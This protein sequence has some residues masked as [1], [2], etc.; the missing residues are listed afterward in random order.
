MLDKKITKI[1]YGAALAALMFTIGGCA[2]VTTNSVSG[3]VQE[4]K[5]DADT[6][7]PNIYDSEDAAVVVKKDTE[8]G[9][10]QLQNIATSRRYTL[11]Y[12]G[13]TRIFDKN[14]V[15]LSMQQLK[16][17]SVVTV[18]FYKP[19]KSLSY[20]KENAEA[21]SLPSL[22]NYELDLKNGGITVGKERY[23]LSGSVVVVSDGRETEPWEL[24]AMD[25]ISV[26]GY[27]DRIYGI[28][29]EKGHGYLR[30]QNED[31][32]VNGWV[33]VGD[34]V[35][36]K[37]EEDMLLVVPEGTYNAMVSH[38]GSSAMQ[39]ITFA[40]NE[41]MVW[42]LGSVEITVV[43]TG[44]I[45]FTLT[46]ATARMAIDG[47]EVDTSKPVEL[48]YGLHSMRII[49]D[50]YDTVAQYIKVA[51][52]SANVSVELEKSSEPESSEQASEPDK[53]SKDDEPS[54]NPVGKK[55]A[56]NT[57][58]NDD[59]DD[60]KES[61]KSEESSS[62]EKSSEEKSSED[63][64]DV[65]SSSDKYKV[66]IDAPE[67]VEAYLNGSYIGITPVSF[68]KSAG[69]HVITLRKTGYQTRSYTLQIDS[70]KKDVNYSFTELVEL[71][72]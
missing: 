41:E 30:L 5:E 66:Y 67:G 14:D 26:W 65:V 1:I 6:K 46:P 3:T 69:S 53:K 20:V 10:I 23:V 54:D 11:N 72:E 34:K 44:K 38:K 39:E 25:V 21:L 60:E 40:R 7:T 37:I 15:A 33:D 42:D 59:D 52:P 70:E 51:E 28:N 45:I 50:G 71:D 8:A 17:G 57:S 43:Q 12:D 13:T 56:S 48:E 63:S 64:G 2:V 61:A 16:E 58:E 9:T 27:Q 24:N 68:P 4:T 18:R 29:V 22:S 31:Y 35:I 36:R 49:A 55:Y 32:F 47:R 62:E 19:D